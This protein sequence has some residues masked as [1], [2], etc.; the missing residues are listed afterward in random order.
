MAVR[1]EFVGDECTGNAAADD[2]D[3]AAQVR[4]QGRERMHQAVLDGPE[5][6]AAL[7]VHARP[8]AFPGNRILAARA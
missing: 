6:I 3:V 1:R 2:G 7:E 8:A 4:L 5:R